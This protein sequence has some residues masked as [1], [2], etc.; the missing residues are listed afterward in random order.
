MIFKILP[1]SL[2]APMW[3]SFTQYTKRVRKED[4]NVLY[5]VFFM[6]FGKTKDFSSEN[7][8]RNSRKL[9]RKQDLNVRYQVYVFFGQSVRLG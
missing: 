8:Q 5:Y 6:P 9:E 1:L 3:P 2:W 7:A 4:L